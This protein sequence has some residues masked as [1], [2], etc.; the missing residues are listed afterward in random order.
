MK[1][2][3]EIVRKYYKNA[4]VET[5]FVRP[6]LTANGTLGGD[7]FAV[8]GYYWH[9]QTGNN[10]IYTLF[11]G[12]TSTGCTCTAY[13]GGGYIIFYNPLPLK[14]TSVQNDHIWYAGDWYDVTISGSN[15]GTNWTD[16]GYF[17]HGLTTK[18][19]I[20]NPQ[21]FNYY[22]LYNNSGFGHDGSG[23]GGGLT[24]IYITGTEKTE[25]IIESTSS[26]YDY[27]VDVPVYK[28]VKERKVKYYK[29]EAWQQPTLTSN[30]TLGGD[31]FAVSASA[32]LGIYEPYYAFNGSGGTSTDN[33]HAPQGVPQWLEWYSPE[34]ITIT[35]ISIT[36][37]K[38]SAFPD[39]INNYQVQTSEDGVTWTT[40][41]SGSNNINTAGYTWNIDLSSVLPKSKYFRLYV[42]SCM[43]RNYVRIFHIVLTAYTVQE[44]SSTNYDF[45]QDEEVYKLFKT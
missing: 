11:D 25:G 30:G 23:Y 35:N 3:K 38:E 8:G 32:S 18:C 16:L 12:N 17:S 45:Y 15:D 27:Y 19:E 22:R 2:Y 33:W 20:S 13:N 42:T 44:G 14:V 21:Y 4:I 7:S 28:I 41:Y 24:E 29:N 34:E 39:A 10:S 37:A 43:N 31:N 9:P 26:D 6:N 5:T 40:I 1:A 36:N